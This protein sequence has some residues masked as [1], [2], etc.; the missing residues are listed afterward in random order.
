MSSTA[1]QRS[2]NVP[3]TW[4]GEP[5]HQSPL[6]DEELIEFA[7][8]GEPNHERPPASI[9]FVSGIEY[10][11][12]RTIEEPKRAKRSMTMLRMGGD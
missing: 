6:D 10:Y 11:P 5:Q 2:T 9:E 3:G 8:Y 4:Y 12:G 7:R 1:R